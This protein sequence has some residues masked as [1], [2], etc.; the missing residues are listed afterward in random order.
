MNFKILIITPES[1]CNKSSSGF[2]LRNLFKSFPKNN[3]NQIFFSRSDIDFQYCQSYWIFSNRGFLWNVGMEISA[4]IVLSKVK[5][6]SFLSKWFVYLDPIID[7]FP[8][9]NSRSFQNWIYRFQPDII[10]TW[11][12]SKRSMDLVVKLSKQFEIPIILHWMD[13]WMFSSLNKYFFLRKLEKYNLINAREI[14]NK[15]VS[16]AIAISDGMLNEYRKYID[17]PMNTIPNGI[18]DINLLRGS[19]HFGDSYIITFGIF[20]RLEFGR[21]L[22]FE[23]FLS[24]LELIVDKKFIVNLYTD[25]VFNVSLNLNSNIDIN[26]FEPPLDNQLVFIQDKI[27]FLLYFDD[28]FDWNNLEYFKYSFS[29]KIPLY[30]SLGKPIITVG[31]VS[32]YSVKFLSD[33]KVGMVVSNVDVKN[34]SF[35]IREF[36]NLPKEK[37]EEFVSNALANAEKFSLR[38]IQKQFYS[39]LE[40]YSNIK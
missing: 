30:L 15:N 8:I 4:E 5:R 35:L 23:R 14:I 19:G 32:N 21:V 29:G 13:N 22:I 16:F 24:A 37:H 3:I 38:A 10:Y 20:G 34:L 9:R 39:I 1:I 17:I 12:G 11:M 28:L 18:E 26:K 25:S 40:K 2:L 33:I 27:D 7:V 31:P 36:L 6:G